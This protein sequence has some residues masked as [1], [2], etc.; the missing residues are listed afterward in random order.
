VKRL[1]LLLT[2][3][4]LA[5]AQITPTAADAIVPVVGSTHGQS[6]ALFRTELQLTNRTG[7]AQGGFLLLRPYGL[8]R[9]YDLPAHAT[10]SFADV[11]ADMGGSGLGSLDILADR[12]VLPA[13]VARAY[14]D[15]P[16]GTTGVGVPAVPVG[17]VLVRGESGTL[18]VPR[19][20]TRYRFNIGV[21]AL[22][23][24]ATVDLILRNAAGATR[25]T[26]SRTYDVNQFEQ[27]PGHT[28]LATDLLADDSIEVTVSAGSAIVYATTVDNMTND[29][30]IQVLTQ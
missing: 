11:V 1:L 24:G 3:S 12:S 27:L 22:G 16:S 8:V 13:V 15:Q 30:S 18:I 9:R 23:S 6:N 19:D 28:F 20:L 5:F 21:R 7:T 25:Q 14:D 26:S 29:S 4:P 17:A 2:L 10:I